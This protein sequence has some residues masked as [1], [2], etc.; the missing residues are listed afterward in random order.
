MI[1]F[2]RCLNRVHVHDQTRH[3]RS[4]GIT[5]LRIPRGAAGLAH[6][7]DETEDWDFRSQWTGGP[8]SWDE[9][10][11]ISAGTLTKLPSTEAADRHAEI[12]MGSR[13]MSPGGR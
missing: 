1:A 12:S 7:D 11:T 9:P 10:R 8:I 4:S 2:R 3:E 13:E 5:G 6:R